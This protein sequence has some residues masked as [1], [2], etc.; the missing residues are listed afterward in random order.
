MEQELGEESI[1]KA[2]WSKVASSLHNTDEV[3]RRC[4]SSL[5]FTDTA[6]TADLLWLSKIPEEGP[7]PLASLIALAD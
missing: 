2:I 7:L 4:T 6:M 3:S 5:G 1:W